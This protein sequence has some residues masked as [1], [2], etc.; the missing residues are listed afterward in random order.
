MST[1]INAACVVDD[2]HDDD[3][4]DDDACSGDNKW[5][6]VPALEECIAYHMTDKAHHEGYVFIP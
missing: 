4:D 6:Y 1:V 2:G 3:D 5:R